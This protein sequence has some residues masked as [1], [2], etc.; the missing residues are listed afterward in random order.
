MGGSGSLLNHRQ[1]AEHLQPPPHLTSTDLP[2]QSRPSRPVDH[3]TTAQRDSSRGLPADDSHSPSQSGACSSTPVQA[4]HKSADLNTDGLVSPPTEPELQPPCSSRLSLFIGM[5]LV[6]K[7]R[8]QCHSERSMDGS[9]GDDER[10]P[11]H[12]SPSVEASSTTSSAPTQSSQPLSAF[13]FLNL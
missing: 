2:A 10:S 3:D 5:Q 12:Q 8:A 9:D 7:G 13:S 11:A 4:D 1:E 6:T